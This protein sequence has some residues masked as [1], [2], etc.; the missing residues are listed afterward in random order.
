M[1]EANNIDI[2]LLEYETLLALDDLW[3]VD[4][5]DWISPHR[6]DPSLY[7]DEADVI[8][9]EDYRLPEPPRL[10]WLSKRYQNMEEIKDAITENAQKAK[11][12]LA[13]ADIRANYLCPALNKVSDNSFEIA[14]TL[15]PTLLM[16][17]TTKVIVVPL[18]PLFIAIVAMMAANAGI[19]SLCR[20]S[21]HK[22]K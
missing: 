8:G 1:A 21:V 4:I 12:L 15:T 3:K 11:E 16:L 7:Q 20:N 10:K 18:G 6:G 22:D 2:Q 5:P 9:F 17:H 19:A 14:K 13:R